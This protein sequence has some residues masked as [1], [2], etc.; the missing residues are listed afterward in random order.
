MHVRTRARYICKVAEPFL[1]N[2][3]ENRCSQSNTVTMDHDLVLEN[4]SSAAVNTVESHYLFEDRKVF[5]Y[6]TEADLLN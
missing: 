3:N 6:Q 1:I 4:S 2:L 5:E